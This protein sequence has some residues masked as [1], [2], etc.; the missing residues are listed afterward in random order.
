MRKPLCIDIFAGLGGWTEGFL[1]EGY[2]VIGFDIERHRYPDGRGYPAQLVLQD[3][4]T[5]HG[6]Q[7]KDADIIVAS[8]PCQFFSRMAMPFKMPWAA[9]EFERRR[10]LAIALFQACFRVQREACEAAGRYIP[11][12][13]ENVRGAV[14]WVGPAQGKFGSYY[15]WGDV[16]A[17]IP[18]AIQ[19]QKFNPDG[20]SHGQGSWF[21]IADSKNRGAG[22]KVASLD[23]GRRTDPGNGVR[24]T[25]RDCGVE[26]VKFGGGWWHD[27]TNNLIRKASSKSS[28][29][30]HASAVIAKIPFA[31][32]RH[33]ARC[34]RPE[35][36][37]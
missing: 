11:L 1:A 10:V 26:G 2:D 31:L 23:G 29:R 20:T 14:K 6:S 33:I 4:L 19:R 30:K 22:F 36:A 28:A 35:R 37:A 18:I 25:S 7:F 13:V 15:L 12:V 34:Y 16:P 24:F 3:V 32:A 17:L 9:E 5:L 21:A 27:A 8:P